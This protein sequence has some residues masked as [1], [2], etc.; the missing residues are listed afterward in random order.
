MA[1]LARISRRRRHVTEGDDGFSLTE[2]LSTLVIMGVLTAIVSTMFITSLKAT[3]SNAGRLEQQNSGRTAMESLS[4]IIRGAVLPSSLGTCSTT[5]SS[6]AAAFIQGNATSMSFYT[7][8]DNSNNAYGPSQV[9]LS[10]S[11]GG[12]L[13]Q[14]TQQADPGSASVGYTWTTC[15]YL[16]A[17]CSK[18]VVVLAQGVVTTGNLFTYYT[19]GSTTPITGTLSAP[20]LANVDAVDIYLQIKLTSSAKAATSTFVQ[21]VSLPN[22]DTLIEATATPGP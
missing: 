18:R 3:Q 15:T 5:C 9:T 17:G 19:F 12:V 21:R 20:Q 22:V 2:M 13:T 10:V 14:T 4:R 11:A 16:A 7:D 6:G 1:A 8:V